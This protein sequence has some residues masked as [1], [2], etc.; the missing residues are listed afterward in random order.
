MDVLNAL[1]DYVTHTSS[2]PS[3]ATMPRLPLAGKGIAG[4]TGAHFIEEIHTPHNLAYVTAT[5][6]STAFQNLVGVTAQEIP[7]RVHATAQAL[8]LAGIKPSD[9]LLITYPPLVNV[10]TKAGLEQYGV[11]WSFLETSSRDALLLALCTRQPRAVV[12][13]SSF[14]RLALA[15]AVKIGLMDKLPTATLFIACGTPLD[16]ELIPTVQRLVS[17]GKV[18]DLYGCQEFGWL[19]LNGVPLRDDVTLFP[20]AVA[21][22]SDLLVG[23]LATGDCFPIASSDTHRHVLDP[24][25]PILTYGRVRSVELETTVL[26][27]TAKASETVERLA[28][29]ILRIKAR[30]VRVS[31]QL[32]TGAPQTILQVAPYGSPLGTGLILDKPDQTTLFDSLLAAQLAYQHQRK[33][34]PTWVKER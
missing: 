12:G 15:D 31:P 9:E 27:T 16:T 24:Q 34:D 13:E 32:V 8:Q 25:G 19:T 6:G 1:A 10:F 23:G 7:A 33:T 11:H 2:A 20:S 4:P 3:L 30:V 14:L 29:T 17:A 5:T 18:H 22:G 21:N 28:R 26:A